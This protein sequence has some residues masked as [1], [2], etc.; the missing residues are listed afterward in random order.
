MTTTYAEAH[1]R[2]D[3]VLGLFFIGCLAATSVAAAHSHWWLAEIWMFAGVILGVI[4]VSER[5]TCE[6]LGELKARNSKS[7]RDELVHQYA[8]AGKFLKLTCLI[9]ATAL[10]TGCALGSPWWGNLLAAVVAWFSSMF[11]IPLVC[12][13]II[14]EESDDGD[15][16]S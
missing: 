1:R 16:S 11:G 2:L 9:A 15:L 5:N 4:K 8:F 13:P 6:S 14:H 10:G 7:R 12:A 3:H